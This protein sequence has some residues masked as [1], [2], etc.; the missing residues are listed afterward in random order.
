MKCLATSVQ[1]LV[2]SVIHLVCVSVCTECDFRKH[3][4]IKV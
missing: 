4:D 1:L 3:A 2:V